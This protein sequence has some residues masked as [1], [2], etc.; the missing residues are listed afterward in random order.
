M[1]EQDLDRNEAA[2]PFKLE[3]AREKGQTARST[4]VV[5]AVVFAVGIAYLSWHGSQAFR[6]LLDLMRGLLVELG[7]ST[8]ESLPLWPLIERAVHAGLALLLPFFV[9]LIVGAVVAT[10]AQSGVVFSWTPL[11]ADFTRIHPANGFKRIF[12]T[13][14]LF[15]TGRGFVKLA[16]LGI[17]AAVALFALLPQFPGVGA[18]EPIAFAQRLLQ[19]TSA[20]GMKL[21]LALGVIAAIDLVYSRGEFLRQMRMSRR[22]LKDEYKNREGDPR[23]RARLRELRREML[24]RS[25]A[26][27][28]TRNADVVLT[29][30]T[31]YAVALRYVHGEMDA[32]KVVAKGA[33]QLAAAMRE[34]AAR[35]RIVVV[36]NPPLARRLF[37]E[38]GIDE[39]LPRSFHVEVAR[40][41]VWVFALR[42]QRQAAGAAA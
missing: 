7:R 31:H 21:A 16:V 38:A 25:M 13:R 8:P 6:Q 15:E 5:A 23:I 33:G 39:Y 1:S 42:Q 12:S 40:I 32:P 11:Q 27:K 36:Q 26:L 35:H 41:I 20:L 9:V 24:R 30:P 22:E 28:N 2:T 19:E 34:I 18:L 17:T 3:K 10:I 37:R 14:T 29:N 4:D